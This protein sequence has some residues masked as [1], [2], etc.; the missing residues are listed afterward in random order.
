MRRCE[1]WQAAQLERFV[2]AARIE[3]RYARCTLDT[4]IVYD[5]EG[6]RRAHE[7]AR[8]FVSQFPIVDK[9]LCFIGPHG[10]GKTHLAVAVLRAVIEKTGARGLFYDTTVL[11]REIRSTYD[12]TVRGEEFSILRPVLEAD[13]LVLDDIGKDRFSDWVEETLNLIVTSRYNDRKLTIFT[14]NYEDNPD[15]GDPRALVCRVG[16][17]VVSRLH[18]MCTVLH[19]EGPDYRG[20]DLPPNAGP[21]DLEMLWR[22]RRTSKPAAALPTRAGSR[23]KAELKPTRELGWSGGKAGS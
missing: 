15:T 18:E 16:T 20:P 19:Y 17:R 13:L 3:R 12:P 6:L 9:G 4:F 21:E 14:S 8:A 1:C 10:V 11:F 23:A 2:A 22:G 5:N 7:H